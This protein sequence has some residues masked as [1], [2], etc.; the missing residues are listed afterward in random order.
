MS[1]SNLLQWNC[2]GIKPNFCEFRLLCDQ[3]DPILCCLQETFLSSTDFNIRGFNSYH[4]T[5]QDIGGR[6]CGGVSILVKE[7]IPQSEVQLNTT[8]QAKAVTISSPKALTVCSLYLSPSINID[9]LLLSNLF[10][11]LP[12]PFII[13]GDFNAHSIVWG[14]RDNNPRGDIVDNFIQSHDLCLLNDGS[15]TYLHPGHGTFSAID[16]SLCSPAIYTELSFQVASD[17][18]GSDHFPIILEYGIALSDGIPR[19]N[20][21]RADWSKFDE[22]CSEQLTIDSIEMYDEPVVVFTNILCD[23]ARQSI[24][25][26][27]PKQRKRCK[28]WFNVE[29]RKALAIRKKA[30]KRFTQVM[31][32]DNHSQFKIA[33]AK[34][35][36]QFR[37]SKK[38]SWRKHVLNINKYTP[39]TKSW[40]MVHRIAGKYKKSTISHVISNNTKV[41]DTE[42][43]TNVIAQSFA[44]NSSK[45]NYTETFNQYRIREERKHI[46]FDTDDN[47]HYNELFTMAELNQAIDRA[48]DSSP[49]LDTVH[50][51]FLKH[52]PLKSLCLLLYIFNQIWVTQEYPNMW[53]IA[54]VIPIPKPGKN[55]SD[56]KN[57]RPIA[58]T[59]CI[60]KTLERMVNN[61]LVWYL[62]SKHIITEHQSGFR[63]RRST[64]DNLVIL[65][66]AI[67]DSFINKRHLVSIFFDLEK[68]YD[69]TWK[70]G[71]LRDLFEAGLR[72]RLPMFVSEFLSDRVFKVRVG[73]TFSDDYTQE[74]GVPQGSILSVTL[75]S[76]KINS[77]VMSLQR[78]VQC[79]LYVD[80]L[81]I[82]YSSSHMPAI[83][84]KLQHCIN[85]LQVW[86][87]QNGF[88]FSSTKTVCVHFCQQRKIHLDPELYLHNE[89]IPVVDQTKFLGI[90]FDRKLSF[91]PH[92]N[93]VKTNCAQALNLIKV[94]AN[95]SWGADRTVLLRL[96]KAFIR[97]KLDY[98]CIV[99]GSA[100]KSYIRRLDPIH[101]QGLRLCSGAFRTSPVYSLHVETN[102]PSLYHR[103]TKLSLQ[104]TVKLMAND[105]NPAYPVVLDPPYRDLYDAKE[106]S[107]KPLGLRIEEHLDSVGFQPHNIATITV[108]HVPPWKFSLPIVNFELSIH[109]KNIT[110]PVEF[111]TYFAEL[112]ESYSDFTHIYTDGSKDANK[113]ALAVVYPS[114]I[115]SKR[116]PD[117]SSIFTAELEAL[118]SALRYVKMTNTD[119]RFVIFSDSKSVLQAISSK[120]EHPAIR[121]LMEYLHSIHFIDK[122]VVFCWIP[123]HMGIQGN[124][125]ADKAAKEA[126]SKDVTECL[127]SYTDARQYISEH[128][129][130][131]WQTEWD[132][133][134]NNKLHAIKPLIGEQPSA[135]RS[136][137]KEEVVMSRLRLG[138]SYLTHSYLLKGEPPPECLT[139][140]CRLTIEHVLVECIEYDFFRPIYFGNHVTLKDVFANVSVNAIISFI[141]RTHLFNKL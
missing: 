119:N 58:L 3:Y 87:D 43:I 44:F 140:Q 136:V 122:E 63:R 17:T 28:P 67:R 118:V 10:D 86:C 60:C 90:I 93:F 103:R 121:I 31:S 53:K 78:H 101:N 112:L 75:F 57:Y 80:D 1:F 73:N 131:L 21:S 36:R 76:L 27:E 34:A 41:T 65:E 111:R 123:S 71:I 39:I 62:E 30:L 49:G 12:T 15:Q 110:N 134:V 83:E 40:H 25:R 29:C 46:D 42:E 94:L 4:Y 139:C 115:Y 125:R 129:K 74:M 7:G 14:C 124:E 11:Q 105:R 52:L 132:L 109:K 116:L 104:Y 22:L 20:L 61:R 141:K 138:H 45:D 13:C 113:T 79:S 127:V 66:S 97:S 2:R 133:A 72:G 117:K 32:E 23:I 24:P 68:A 89:I 18:F 85:S 59:S 88:K 8:L 54:L 77:L 56:P 106:N 16:L 35:R 108:S 92:I 38:E 81:C 107:I 120:W 102:E 6:A 50:Y 130:K 91:I 82:Y 9:P 84:R 128:V 95:T 37:A 26:S 137:R 100:R 99:Y 5:S 47:L 135:S 55:H 126:L 33:R 48:H 69:T 98:G 51:Q 19:W 64:V 114:F 96:Y 70:Y